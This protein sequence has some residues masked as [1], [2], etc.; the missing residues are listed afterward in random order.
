M[1]GFEDL[2]LGP[3]IGVML[4]QLYDAIKQEK[5][6][7][8]KFDLIP[9]WN[10]IKRR[11]YAKRLA[12]FDSSL[13]RLLNVEFQTDQLLDIKKILLEVTEINK[14]LDRMINLQREGSP[15]NE[16]NYYKPKPEV[17]ATEGSESAN[18]GHSSD[19]EGKGKGP[20]FQMRY[21]NEKVDIKVGF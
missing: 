10:K 7:T 2:V 5:T 21:K 8:R 11:S 16:N 19:H 1:P 15:V 12:D 18:P 13:C 4:Q 17:A 6:R 20:R 3:L 14:K 9:R